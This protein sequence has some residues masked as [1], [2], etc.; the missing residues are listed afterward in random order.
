MKWLQPFLPSLISTEQGTFVQGSDIVENILLAQEVMHSLER[1]APTR[2]LAVLK[3]D[4]EKAYD[5]IHWPFLF[6]TL[7]QFG[8]HPSFMAWIQD[9]FHNFNLALLINDILSY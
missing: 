9:S 4:M 8:F 2:G 6:S 7:A 3:I 1:A 5:W